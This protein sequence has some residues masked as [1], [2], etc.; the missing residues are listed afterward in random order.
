MDAERLF[1]ETKQGFGFYHRAFGVKYPFGRVAK[2]SPNRRAAGETL[3]APMTDTFLRC[4]PSPPTTGVRPLSAHV[5]RTSGF[6]SNPV[7]S[8]R[9]TW[10]FRRLAF[11]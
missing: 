9:T 2:Y 6:R 7:S 10:A 1:T 11:F 4:P 8:I 3:T 5:R